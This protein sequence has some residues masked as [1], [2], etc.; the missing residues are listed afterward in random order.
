MCNREANELAI[1]A[2]EQ[3]VSEG[4]VWHKFAIFWFTTQGI[5]LIIRL[6]DI[7][8]T[9]QLKH[10]PSMNWGYLADITP[11]LQVRMAPIDHC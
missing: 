2:N 8:I 1:T 7:L 6:H 3:T 9:N 11:F 5:V 10:T 4:K